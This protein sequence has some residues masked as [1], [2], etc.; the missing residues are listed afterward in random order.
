MT[1]KFIVKLKKWATKKLKAESKPIRYSH[2]LNNRQR[3]V[4]MKNHK[5][6]HKNPDMMYLW[7]YKFRYGFLGSLRV[8]FFKSIL[9][10]IE[11]YENKTKITP[12]AD[13]HFNKELK[14]LGANDESI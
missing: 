4:V 6:Y 12:I 7:N 1:V 2:Y 3:D 5:P 10:N 8:K 9:N 13:E 11:N 14:H